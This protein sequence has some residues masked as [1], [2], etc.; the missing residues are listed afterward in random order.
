MFSSIKVVFVLEA[1]QNMVTFSIYDWNNVMYRFAV[2]KKRF[3]TKLTEPVLFLAT[4]SLKSFS[5]THKEASPVQVCRTQSRSSRNPRQGNI[6]TRAKKTDPIKTINSFF[7]RIKLHRL[8]N[9]VCLK[10]LVS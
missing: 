1:I 4:V 9:I 7:Q 5:R 6:P 8:N 2:L 10:N 3:E